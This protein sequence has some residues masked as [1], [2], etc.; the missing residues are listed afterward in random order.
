MA[1]ADDKVCRHFRM[2]L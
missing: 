2:Q 1:T